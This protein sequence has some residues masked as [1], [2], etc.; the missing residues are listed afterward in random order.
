MSNE[1]DSSEFLRIPEHVRAYIYR[2]FLA[3]MPLL[4]MAGVLTG[5]TAPLALAVVQ[6]ILGFGL[7]S[8]N[9]STGR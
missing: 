3:T 5:G 7:A 9:T 8:V 4:V 6:A 1:V 2:V